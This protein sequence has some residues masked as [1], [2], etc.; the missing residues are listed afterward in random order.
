MD[1]LTSN[2]M[3]LCIIAACSYTEII[4][5]CV[6]SHIFGGCV[7]SVVVHKPLS[8]LLLYAKDYHR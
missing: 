1:T 8:A 5:M 2:R 6:L 7:D 4:Q 3:L